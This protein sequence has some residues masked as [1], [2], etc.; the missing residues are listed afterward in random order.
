M[1]APA[2][3]TRCHVPSPFPLP[4]LPL[5]PSL[6]PL[7]LGFFAPPVD[8][9]DEEDGAEEDADF[10]EDFGFESGDEADD[11]EGSRAGLL[12]TVLTL[13][14]VALGSRRFDVFR[15]KNESKA[16]GGR[17]GPAAQSRDC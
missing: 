9:A 3:S 12:F 13:L 16:R 7:P 15:G 10:P 6:P 17:G 11:D 5:L 8:E 1:A 2:M 14:L 4:P